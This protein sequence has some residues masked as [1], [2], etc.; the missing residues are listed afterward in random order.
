MRQRSLVT[1]ALRYG[2][3][4]PGVAMTSASEVT[5]SRSRFSLKAKR[6]EF[7]DDAL[8]NAK[9]LC[10]ELEISF[11]TPRRIRRKQIFGD[12]NKDVQ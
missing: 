1:Y 8:I 12:G 3:I 6:E 11:E 7:V 9:S 5:L 2:P 4:G 10:E